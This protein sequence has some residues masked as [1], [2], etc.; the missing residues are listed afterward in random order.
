MYIFTLMRCNWIV[1]TKNRSGR[2]CFRT[3]TIIDIQSPHP[4]PFYGQVGLIVI[5]TCIWRFKVTYM[6]G[7]HT[8]SIIASILTH[9]PW[10][11]WPPFWQTTYS[12][13]FTWMKIPIHISLKHVH[14]S[15]I[16]IK[17][18]LAQLMAWHWTG[19]KP[20]PAPMM[21][22]FIDSYMRHKEDTS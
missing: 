11:K 17:P 15:P 6:R 10:T 5:A 8:C 18:A 4:L 16:A 13:A 9:P 19:D 1:L 12:I 20:L 21:T 2:I 22:Q 7:V 14:R 3:H